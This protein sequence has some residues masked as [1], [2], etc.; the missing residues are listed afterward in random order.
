MVL[1]SVYLTDGS[2]A[3][4]AI[5]SAMAFATANSQQSRGMP[6][7]LVQQWNRVPMVYKG[8]VAGGAYGGKTN[9]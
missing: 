9:G 1:L 5:S 6:L 8:A 4:E 3:N 7:S 2:F